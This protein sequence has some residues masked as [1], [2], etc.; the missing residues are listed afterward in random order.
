MIKK[1]QKE[2]TDLLPWWLWGLSC[3]WCKCKDKGVG[4]DHLG[5][6]EI[7]PSWCCPYPI[8]L[9]HPTSLFCY[10]KTKGVEKVQIPYHRLC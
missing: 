10:E 1:R 8:G 7:N 6:W 5:L 3:K 2:T 4:I 9:F